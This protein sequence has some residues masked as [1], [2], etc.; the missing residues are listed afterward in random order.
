MQILNLG[1]NHH[2]APIDIRESVAIHPEDL[3]DSLNR[4]LK[5]FKEKTTIECKVESGTS[6]KLIIDEELTD[7]NIE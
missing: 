5:F 1:V 6:T 7:L 4:T 3:Q 2:T